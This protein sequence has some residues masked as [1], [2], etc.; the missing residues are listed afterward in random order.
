MDLCWRE[1]FLLEMTELENACSFTSQLLL[2]GSI[3][4]STGEIPV[5]RFSLSSCGA[6]YFSA[7]AFTVPVPLAF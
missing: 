7:L 3:F 6:S 1:R 5:S 2:L 4:I